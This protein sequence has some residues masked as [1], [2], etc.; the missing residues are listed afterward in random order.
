MD[1]IDLEFKSAQSTVPHNVIHYLC[2]AQVTRGGSPVVRAELEVNMTV[3]L[4]NGSTA[5]VDNL[6]MVDNGYG[7]EC[8]R[9][10]S[11]GNNITA[12]GA[13]VAHD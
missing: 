2:I 12:T 3:R 8:Q 11:T 4:E 7:G 1:F 6:T 13:N 5:R 10:A 9:V